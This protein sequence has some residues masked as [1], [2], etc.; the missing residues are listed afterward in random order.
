MKQKGQ[1]VEILSSSSVYRKDKIL[2]LPNEADLLSESQKRT[3][4]LFDGVL[5]GEHQDLGDFKL[6]QRKGINLGGKKKPMY[7]IGIDTQGNRLFV[8]E[9][10]DHPGLF[11]KVLAIDK[12]E[13]E[14]EEYFSTMVQN[15]SVEVKPEFEEKT[16][17]AQLLPSEDYLFLKLER[18]I[19]IDIMN[20]NISVFYKNTMIYNIK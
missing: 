10:A 6:G 7:V 15:D 19:R 18:P 20:H 3:Y 11:I 1:I 17:P 14:N 8:G 16:I 13:L 4:S 2:S 5:V 12:K 9:G